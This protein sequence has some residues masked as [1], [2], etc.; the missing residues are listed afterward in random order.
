[1][2]AHANKLFGRNIGSNNRSSNGPPG[3]GAFGQEKIL[4]IS[5]LSPFVFINPVAITGN[6]DEINKENNKLIEESKK[7]ERQK[8]E[9]LNVFKKQTKL[10]EILKKQKTHLELARSLSFSED[11][12]IKALDLNEKILN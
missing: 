3:Q 10:I 11:E 9:L 6:N 1:M 2:P 7:L 12:F 8:L 4:T 5:R